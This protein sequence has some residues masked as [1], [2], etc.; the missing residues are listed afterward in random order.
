MFEKGQVRA[1]RGRR[2]ADNLTAVVAGG[3]PQPFRYEMLGETLTLGRYDGVAQI[4]HRHLR[5]RLQRYLRRLYHITR[6]PSL[7]RRVHVWADWTL[8]V[9][10]GREIVSLGELRRPNLPLERAAN[11]QTD[12]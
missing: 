11:A 10:T 8:R 5:G 3:Q 1:A 6:I 9:L 12:V 4:R 2:L 7:R